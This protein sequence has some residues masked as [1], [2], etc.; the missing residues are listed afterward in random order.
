MYT[1][2]LWFDAHCTENMPQTQHEVAL[3]ENKAGL[4]TSK[5]TVLSNQKGR[6]VLAT[7]I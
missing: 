5:Q 6:T 7:F 1:T 2:L 4:A 3:E